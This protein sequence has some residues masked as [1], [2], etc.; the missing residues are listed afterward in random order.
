[1]PINICKLYGYV[2]NVSRKIQSGIDVSANLIGGPYYTEDGLPTADYARTQTD[3]TGYFELD[4]IPSTLLF[5]GLD[6]TG[7]GEYYLS[8]DKLRVNTPLIIPNQSQVDLR[9]LLASGI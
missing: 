5:S 3:S 8:I 4:L 1:M 2:Y 7:I 9:T 6:A